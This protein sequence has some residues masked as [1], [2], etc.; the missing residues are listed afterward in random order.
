[1]LYIDISKSLFLASFPAGTWCYEQRLQSD[2]YLTFKAY[3]HINKLCY[4][5]SSY[6][7]EFRLKSVLEIAIFGFD[8]HSD[9]L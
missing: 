8:P 6:I 7:L 2:I 3:F 5:T 4:W 1:M 9:L